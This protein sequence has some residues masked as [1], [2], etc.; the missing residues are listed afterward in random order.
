MLSKCY[1]VPALE[2]QAKLFTC[3]ACSG[4]YV[5]DEI[6]N[7]TSA[8]NTSSSMTSSFAEW[9]LAT[10]RNLKNTYIPSIKRIYESEYTIS[11]L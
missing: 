10:M 3:V 5:C 7:T 6:G 2:K 1:V 4:P 9:Y 8:A 11:M